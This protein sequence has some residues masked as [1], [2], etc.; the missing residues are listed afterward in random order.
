MLCVGLNKKVTTMEWFEGY[1]W[2]ANP[3]EINHVTNLISGVEDIRKKMLE[4]IKSNDCCLLVG[5][6]GSGKTLLL[7]WLEGIGT[8]GTVY[9]YLNTIGMTEKE[10]K[11]NILDKKIKENSGFWPK[12]KSVVVLVDDAESL[13]SSIGD[14]LKVNFENKTINSVVLASET[15]ELSSLRANLLGE[16]GERVI[17]M[18]PLT[19]DEATVMIQNRVLSINPFEQASLELIFQKAGM[20]PRKILEF[21][22]FVAKSNTEKVIT[23]DFVTKLFEEKGKKPVNIFENLS[24]L[25]REIV[26]ILRTG[27]FRPVDIAVRLGKQSKTITSQL[28]YLSLKAGAEMMKRKGVEHPLVEKVSERPTKYRLKEL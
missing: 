9:I 26:E 8:Q 24:P 21:C 19:N 25:Q 4:F 23:A 11:E 15:T 18:R 16:V 3:F 20:R 12:K 28:A 6:S 10:M 22:E 17:R 1:G 27:D 14:S 2:S 5:P 7:K 13:T